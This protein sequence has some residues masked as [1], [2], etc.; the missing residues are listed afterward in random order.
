[1]N[2]NYIIYII[3]IAVISYFIYT[4]VNKKPESEATE[5][6]ND[7]TDEAAK[8]KAK[9]EADAAA[10]ITAANNA[11]AAAEAAA[12][13]AQQNSDAYQALNNPA[14]T[15]IGNQYPMWQNKTYLTSEYVIYN[16]NLYKNTQQITTTNNQTPDKDNRWQKF[17]L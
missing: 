9:A 16:N 15:N 17:I 5:G 7:A 10:A 13:T 11:A 8:A 3:A 12:I 1:M 2:K 4:Y 6:G 14:A